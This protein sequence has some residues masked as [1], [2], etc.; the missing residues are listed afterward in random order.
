MLGID[1]R[2]SRMQSE[3]STIFITVE[4]A[5]ISVGKQEFTIFLGRYFFYTFQYLVVF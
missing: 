3:R 4:E 1:P 2:N 5:L